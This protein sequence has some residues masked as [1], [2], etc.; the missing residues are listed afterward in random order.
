MHAG[1]QLA[2]EDLVWCS[3]PFGDIDECTIEQRIWL[4]AFIG[5]STPFGDIDECTRRTARENAGFAFDVLNAFRR[6]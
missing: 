3:T 6:H 2:F 1:K 4:G 5:C